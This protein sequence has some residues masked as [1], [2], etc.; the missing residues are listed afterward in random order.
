MKQYLALCQRI[1]DDGVWI[2]NERTGKRCLTVI[3]ADLTYDVANN[4]FPLITTRK[5]FWK[6]AIAELLGYLRGYDNAAQFRAI[7]CN[8]WNANANDN[9][10]WLNNPHRKGEDDMGRV[11]GVQGRRWQKPDGTPIDQ[12]KKIVDDLTKGIDDR[13]EILTFY[14]P[15]EFDMGCLRPCMHTHTFSLLGDTLYL[16]SYQRSCDVPLGLNFNQVQ[17]FTLLALMAQITGHKAG[18]AYHKIINA[19]IYEDQLE[20][21]RDVQLKREPF[22]SPQLKINPKIK[23]L[24]DLETWVTLDDFE[25]IGYEHHDAIQYPFSV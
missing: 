23:S 5:S 24:E 14:N 10:A 3:N 9:Q 7:G 18:Q 16:T 6:A 4:Q 15:G 25:V 20:L 11:Y 22:A 17:V 1:V 12:L 13:G 2:E 21:M 8:T 19:H